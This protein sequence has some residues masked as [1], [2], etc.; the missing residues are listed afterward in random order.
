MH[1]EAEHVS[2]VCIHA[3]STHP[4]LADGCTQASTDSPQWLATLPALVSALQRYD[5]S[6]LNCRT[7]HVLCSVMMACTRLQATTG[8][9]CQHLRCVGCGHSLVPAGQGQC[10]QLF[11]PDVHT[12]GRHFLSVSFHCL[13]H[14]ATPPPTRPPPPVA[15]HHSNP[16][17]CCPTG[18]G[19]T[20]TY[21]LGNCQLTRTAAQVRCRDPYTDAPNTPPHRPHSCIAGPHTDTHTEPD[22][23]HTHTE[24]HTETQH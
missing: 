6:A 1:S 9:K 18:T 23:A 8:V 22:T 20:L 10:P 4:T 2:Y 13:P 14:L 16:S 12:S 17:C 15:V 5:T 11:T 21:N 19:V 3:K 24:A 7:F